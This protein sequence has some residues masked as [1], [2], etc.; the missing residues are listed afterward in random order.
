MTVGLVVPFLPLPLW[1]SHDEQQQDMEFHFRIVDSETGKP[2][3]H[4]AIRL[5][6]GQNVV[7]DLLTGPD[8]IATTTEPCPSVEKRTLF[9]RRRFV[10]TPDWTFLVSVLG[11]KMAGPFPVREQAGMWLELSD[12]SP[13]PTIQVR[14]DKQDPFPTA[15]Q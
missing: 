9:S 10:T 7:R 1:V 11:Y 13:F 8:G 5:F 14:M 6:S 3:G 4:A 12:R 15:K 2:L